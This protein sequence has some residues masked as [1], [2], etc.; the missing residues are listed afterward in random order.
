MF[1]K[2]FGDSEF[3]QSFVVEEEINRRV[4]I[5]I[6]EHEK[7]EKERRMKEES[8]RKEKERIQKEKEKERERIQKEKER[9]REKERKE[10]EEKMKKERLER[11]RKEKERRDEQIRIEREREKQMREKLSIKILVFSLFIPLILEKA[12]FVIAK[13]LIISD[14]N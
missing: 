14:L 1:A 5:T 10:K 4:K 9:E 6:T 8:E 7:I 11:E 2:L 12:P 13:P 3:E